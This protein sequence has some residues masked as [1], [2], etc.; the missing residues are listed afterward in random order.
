MWS[1]RNL[2]GLTGAIP[3]VFKGSAKLDGDDPY[4]VTTINGSPVSEFCEYFESAPATSSGSGPPTPCIDCPRDHA[5]CAGPLL[6]ADRALEGV[7]RA[8]QVSQLPTREP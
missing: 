4:A 2:K 6:H 3:T 1:Y 5:R 8:G 7:D